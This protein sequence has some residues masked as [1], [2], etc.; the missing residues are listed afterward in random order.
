MK[1]LPH[2]LRQAEPPKQRRTTA[3]RKPQSRKDIDWDS[4]AKYSH[5]YTRK[6]LA[7]MLGMPVSTVQ[8]AINNGLIRCKYEKWGVTREHV[9]KLNQ[10]GYSVDEIAEKLQTTVNNVKVHMKRLRGLQ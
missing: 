7:K 4:I 3:E 6:E 10:M 2:E 8:T 1:I 5:N 9:R